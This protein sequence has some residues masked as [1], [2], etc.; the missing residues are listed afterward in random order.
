MSEA[1]RIAKGLTK[2]QREAIKYARDMNSNHGGYPFFTVHHTGEPW[3]QGIAEF[4]SIWR[5]RLTPL[6]L[7]VR[8]H[9]KETQH[10]G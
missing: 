3:P 4:Q 8:A 7:A 10:E 6:G 9:L 5:D 1:E 2:T